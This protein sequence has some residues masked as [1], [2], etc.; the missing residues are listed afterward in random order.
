MIQR[1]I[2][3]SHALGLEELILLKQPCYPKQH[4]DLM[5]SLIKIPKI[6]FTE[7]EQIIPKFIQKHKRLRVA[8]AILRKKNKVG[9]I[10]FSR[11]QTVLQNYSDLYTVVMAHRSME[12]N[13]QPRNKPTH[14][15]GQLIFN[16]GGQNIQ[17]KKDSLFNQQCWASQ[18]VSC[19][20]MKFE[21]SLI[22]YTKI[23]SK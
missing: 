18:T 16:R 13:R 2:K 1:N 7:T 10:T 22:P 11:F 9:G 14:L 15:Y 4:T 6:F 5:Q 19:K 21:H 23:N 8:K 20:S 17:C 12:Q 3:I